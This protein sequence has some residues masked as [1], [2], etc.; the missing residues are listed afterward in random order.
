MSLIDI[1]LE[2]IMYSLEA[3]V[4]Q[5]LVRSPL[6]QK[7]PSSTPTSCRDFFLPPL[8]PPSSNGKLSLFR[9][10]ESKATWK[11]T[12]HPTTQCRWRRMNVPLTGHFPNVCNRHGTKLYFTYPDR[13]G[14]FH[15][16]TVS[17]PEEH[18]EQ[19]PFYRRVTLEYWQYPP[20][21]IL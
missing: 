19:Q 14:L 17:T 11:G 10:S 9:Q 12:R 4:A 1:N 13:T 20:L 16:E 2:Y 6:K 3:G 8:C 15:P 7:V 18:T 5:W 21:P